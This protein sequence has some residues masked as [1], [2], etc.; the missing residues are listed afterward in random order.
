MLKAYP[1]L[2]LVADIYFRLW[3]LVYNSYNVLIQ[4]YTPLYKIPYY[5]FSIVVSM[6]S[7]SILVFFLA[8]YLESN[9]KYSTYL[10]EEDK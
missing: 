6:D 1:I 7:L 4:K 8:L 3:V 2:N 10:S 5:Y 9:Y